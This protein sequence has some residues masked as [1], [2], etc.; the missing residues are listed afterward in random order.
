MYYAHLH[1]EIASNFWVNVLNFEH[2]I[3]HFL[4]VLMYTLTQYHSYFTIPAYL[5]GLKVHIYLNFFN[6]VVCNRRKK[7]N[8]IALNKH[9]VSRALEAFLN[10]CSYLYIFTRWHYHVIM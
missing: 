1:F 3:Q 4:S 9:K 8:T 2:D 10:V 5:P 6:P 7:V